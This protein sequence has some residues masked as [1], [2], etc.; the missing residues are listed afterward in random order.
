[1][2]D[3]PAE[4]RV[5]RVAPIAQREM[6][7]FAGGQQRIVEM[8]GD[9]HRAHRGLR[10]RGAARR[11]REQHDALARLAQPFEAMHRTGERRHAVMD[12]APE[13]DDEAVIAG[14]ERGEAVVEFHRVT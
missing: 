10:R 7:R 5:P 8:V 1:M 11:V 12:D 9:A 2:E 13:V 6:R 4:R 3:A 14:G